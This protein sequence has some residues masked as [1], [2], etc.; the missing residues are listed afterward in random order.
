MLHNYKNHTVPQF[1]RYFIY[2][3]QEWYNDAITWYVYM[4]Q[5]YKQGFNDY[6]KENIFVQN[7]I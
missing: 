1:I 3:L 5:R 7:Y 6:N 2:T 4:V